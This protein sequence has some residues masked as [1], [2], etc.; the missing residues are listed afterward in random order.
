ML[1]SSAKVLR[2]RGGQIVA[3][4]VDA[5]KDQVE[6]VCA[7]IEKIFRDHSKGEATITTAYEPYD[8][9]SDFLRAM[10]KAFRQVQTEKNERGKYGSSGEALLTSSYDRRCDLLP[11]Q[12]AADREPT[13]DD[14][15]RMMSYAALA[16]WAAVEE[17]SPFDTA[18][19]QK[20]SEAGIPDGYKLPYQ[21]EDL[22]EQEGEGRYVGLVMADGNSFGQMLETIGSRLS[23]RNSPSNFTTDF[24]RRSSSCGKDKNAVFSK[25]KKSLASFDSHY[26]CRR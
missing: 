24:S 18:L 4:L 5:T 17:R 26:P 15:Y 2:W 13:G 19:K 9:S 3:H 14:E 25:G 1:E 12:A 7:R 16:R 23:M 10:H 6:Y 11:S 22:W 21:P 8:S 20:L